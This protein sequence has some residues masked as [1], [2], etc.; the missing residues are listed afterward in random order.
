MLVGTTL[1]DSTIPQQLHLSLTGNL[2]EMMIGWMTEEDTATSTVVYW[3]T[4]TSQNSTTTGE[5]VHYYLVDYISPAIHYVKLLGLTPDTTYS[6]I[7]G[8]SNGGWSDVS[9]FH[10]EPELSS[11]WPSPTNPL[12]IVSIADQGHEGN[13]TKVVNAIL[14]YHQQFP[15][16]FIIHS[17]DISYANGF[18]SIWDTWGQIADPLAR[19]VPWMVATGNHEIFWAFVPYLWRFYMP[20]EQSGG[21]QGNLY[22]SFNYGNVHLMALS[23]EEL[24]FWHFDEQYEWME[25]DLQNVDRTTQG[26]LI[27]SWHTPWYCSNV[28]HYD[29]GED[30][31]DSFEDL[32]YDNGLDVSLSGHVHA[33]ER[34]STIYKNETDPKGPVYIVNGVGGTEEGL[35]NQWKETPSWSL[36]RDGKSWGF[37]VMEIHNNTHMLWHFITTQ[38]V[39]EDMAWIVRER[40]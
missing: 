12:R 4:G 14:E 25:K 10:S 1:G 13:A 36:F 18:Q 16:D 8:D 24:E 31:R 19:Q 15:I 20:Y 28:A 3:K 26:W 29:A 2:Q 34:C 11:S 30:M 23:S 7:V 5:A 38:G 27:T 17:G 9:S 40:S 21:S 39:Q 35:Y 37:G 33:Y 22:Y 6:Y 32:L